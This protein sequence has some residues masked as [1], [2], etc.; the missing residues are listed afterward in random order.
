M[1][2]ILEHNQVLKVNL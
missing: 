1:L 2:K